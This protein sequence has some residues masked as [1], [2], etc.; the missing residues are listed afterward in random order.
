MALPTTI[1]P[2]ADRALVLRFGDRIDPAVN[3]L[4]IAAWRTIDAGRPA[5]VVDLVPA[6]TTLTVHY[7]WRSMPEAAQER[8]WRWLA[9][10]LRD[11]LDTGATDLPSAGRSVRLPVCYEPPHAPDLPEVARQAGLAVDEIVARHCAGEYTVASIGFRPGFPYLLG[12]DPALAVPRL[13]VPRARVEAGSVGLAGRQTGIYPTAGAGGWRLI[14]ATPLRLFA[15]DRD[16]PSLLMPGDR[17]RFEAIDGAGF[18]R[19][20]ERERHAATPAT[21]AADHG[22]P[23]LEV[24]APGIHS[25][26]QD[27]GRP[28]WR[29]L[30]IGASGASDP[31]HA[32]LANA[33]VGNDEDAAVLE[34][35][36]RG[37]DLRVLRPLLLALTGSGMSATADDEPLRFG[38]PVMLALGTQLRF[39]P[40]GE[41]ARAWLAVAGGLH[42]RRWL[43]SVAVDSGSGLHGRA[44]RAGEL[45][46]VG[47]PARPLATGYRPGWWAASPLESH[48]PDTPLRFVVH[49]H[50]DPDLVAALQHT[51]AWRIGHAAD[52]TG[53]RLEGPALAVPDAGERISEGVLHG[54]IQVPASGQPIVLGSDCQ[55]IGGYPVAGHVIEADLPRLAQ[56]KPGDRLGLQAVDLDQA[57]AARRALSQSMYRQHVAIGYRSRTP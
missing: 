36:I 15:V 43:G 16:P 23:V 17:M 1:A 3:A 34:M 24:L 20:A 49:D 25:S 11:R 2:L 33:L 55:T 12:L 4:V 51:S 30:G 22:T 35:A 29:H 54:T 39:R 57:H 40:T 21:D 26:L 10:R 38:Q 37:P 7:D 31:V 44:L 5:G 9:D 8:P 6:Y 42:G 56:L 46:G 28:G 48:H 52:R 13:A 41:G 14:G 47:E 45:L 50:A 27:R 19:L 32:A 18:A 53:W